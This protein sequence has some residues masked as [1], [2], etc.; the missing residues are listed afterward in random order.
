MLTY[1][2]QIKNK[3]TEIGYPL[4]FIILVVCA[5]S[6]AFLVGIHILTVVSIFYF[7]SRNRITIQ[8]KTVVLFLLAIFY[9][10]FFLISNGFS[11]EPFKTF[12]FL[13]LWLVVYNL[14]KDK[15]IK[16]IFVFILL[17]GFGMAIHGIV[18][19]IYN[20]INGTEMIKGRSYDFW[21]QTYSSATGQA[22]NFTLFISI[23]F[24]V[25]FLQRNFFL[26]LLG[27]AIFII[28]L[29]YDV[30][31]GGRTFLV[32]C[33]GSIALGVLVYII[34]NGAV[35]GNIKKTLLLLLSVVIVI[36]LFI[37][38]FNQNW[39]G[40]RTLYENSYLA[41]RLDNP[42][43]TDL[44]EDGRI[45]KK[46]YYLQHFFDN[47]WGGKLMEE[48]VGS[49]HEL[50]LDVYDTAGIIPYVLIIIF[51]FQSIKTVWRIVRERKIEVSYRV[52][53][54]VYIFVILAQFFVEPILTGSPML[55]CSYLMIDAALTR[56]CDDNDMV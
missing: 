2:E 5:V 23:S 14:S 49:S 42:N 13:L 53:L 7:L 20:T 3:K 48:A 29:V 10:I 16:Q 12:T 6:N 45:E 36:L 54:A 44:R 17:L 26:K 1:T 32:L 35:G 51:T 46:M 39:F 52:G 41:K 55:F 19:F 47:L 33:I 31:L 22:I 43:S 24:W 25:I 37:V 21:S 34:V 11:L 40:I 9:T 4:L 18:N 38:A 50:W 56:F 27:I 8:N 30:Q 15:S 28:S